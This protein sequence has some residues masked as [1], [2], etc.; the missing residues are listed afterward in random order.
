MGTEL[1]VQVKR[2]G[3]AKIV[4]IIREGGKENPNCICLTRSECYMLYQLN[5]ACFLLICSKCCSNATI[6][7]LRDEELF[8]RFVVRDSASFL[9]DNAVW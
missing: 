1:E 6:E 5:S 9:L 2:D 8:T 3:V 4:K 7:L